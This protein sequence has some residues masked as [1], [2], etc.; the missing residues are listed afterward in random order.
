MSPAGVKYISLFSPLSMR[1]LTL[2]GKSVAP[3]KVSRVNPGAPCCSVRPGLPMNSREREN[4]EAGLPSA[5][6]V[7]VRRCHQQELVSPVMW[8]PWPVQISMGV[9]G[10]NTPEEPEVVVGEADSSDGSGVA[11]MCSYLVAPDKHL[12]SFPFQ[13]PLRTLVQSFLL[14]SSE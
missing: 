6:P 1:S 14:S 3:Y 8:A 4:W 11:S 2:L 5:S 7:A 9:T 13:A 10:T 12:S